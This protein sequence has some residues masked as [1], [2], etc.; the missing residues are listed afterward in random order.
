MGILELPSHR[1]GRP[2]LRS[3]LIRPRRFRDESNQIL[4]PCSLARGFGRLVTDEPS[5]PL[6]GLSAIQIERSVPALSARK[7][8]VIACSTC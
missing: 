6:F 1:P 4:S 5:V 8:G 7:R 3:E 2:L